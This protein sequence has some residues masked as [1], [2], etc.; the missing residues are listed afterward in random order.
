MAVDLH[1]DK[2]AWLDTIDLTPSHRLVAARLL[3]KLGVMGRAVDHIDAIDGSV[4]ILCGTTLLVVNPWGS[5]IEWA[6]GETDNDGRFLLAAAD[7]DTSWVGQVKPG[8]WKL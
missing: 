2:S 4:N 7:G 3:I 6:D 8:W 5:C 1:S